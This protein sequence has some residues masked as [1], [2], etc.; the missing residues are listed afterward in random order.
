MRLEEEL[1]R[2]LREGVSGVGT[3]EEAWD[4]IER[5]LTREASGR[6]G[7]RV[8]VAALALTVS[9]ASLVG[10]WLAFRFTPTNRLG[11]EPA[12]LDPRV[13]AVVPVGP[14]PGDVAVGEGA[15]WVGVPAQPP[16][17]DRQ[18][19]VRIDPATDEV[20]ARIP[21]D[22]YIEELA[23]GEGGVWANAVAGTAANPVFSIVRIDPATSEEIATIEDVSGPLAVGEGGLWAVDRA[24]ARA[25]PEGST[26]LRIDP[27]TN[28][29]AARIP[30]GV[31]L[32]DVEVGEGYVWVLTFEPD[33]GDGDILQVDPRTDEVVAR[34]D[35]PVSGNVFAPALGEGSAWVPV[36]CV[37]NELNLVRVEASS[38]QIVGEPIR[39]TKAGAPVA[40]AAGHVWMVA[41][42]GALYGLNVAT[43]EVDE[44]LS[45]FD[46]PAG[47][48]PDPS[49]ELDTDRLAVWVA[50]YRDSVT[51]IDLAASPGGGPSPLEAEGT[52]L[53]LPDGWHGRTDPLPGY[54]H[55]IFQAATFAVPPLDDIEATDARGGI[56]PDDVLIVLE[57]FSALCPPCPSESSGLPIALGEDDFEDPNTVPKWLPP[58]SNVPPDHALARRIFNVGPRYFDLRV[59]FGSAPARDD[60][61]AEVNE[62]LATLSVGEWV[63]EPNGVCQWNEIGMRDPDCPQTQ[64]LREVLTTAGFEIDEE[65]GSG[66]W[67]ARSNDVEFFIWV[68]EADAV[69]EDHLALLKD[70]D[71]FPVREDVRGV[72]VYGN[73]DGWQWRTERVH[74]FIRQGPDGD[75]HVASLGELTALVG[76]SLE[77]QYPPEV[78]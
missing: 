57:E 36:C 16:E 1:R 13:T 33:Q 29:V 20:V 76:R 38:G 6:L 32:W 77:V 66:S 67:V 40:V 3:S 23:A 45:G 21:M 7:R 25:G 42:D 24:G 12:D 35:V 2:A 15:V 73:D 5:R 58:L 71:A 47:T 72:T 62:V 4:E 37:D 8:A 17:Q 9:A 78:A 34:I 46:W 60:L 52:S 44:T 41:E 43:S 26:L 27:G 10:L 30:L 63:P 49:A 54:T 56:G 74:V 53:V 55:P 75:S 68:Q 65:G 51:R 59:E 70:L 39:V 22:D 19:I 18:L 28:R 50:N 14:F 11:G 69:S 48:F 64:W 61:L 31:A